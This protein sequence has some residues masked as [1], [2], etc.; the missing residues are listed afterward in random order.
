M[1]VGGAWVG[2]SC[3][4][5]DNERDYRQLNTEGCFQTYRSNWDSLRFKQEEEGSNNRSVMSFRCS[6]LHARYNVRIK[7]ITGPKGILVTLAIPDVV[8]IEDCNHSHE[9]GIPCKCVSTAH[10][11]YVPALCTH[12]PSL[13]PM[14]DSVKLSDPTGKGN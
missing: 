14:D 3:V 6:G 1:A 9:P 8:G 12:R 2:L 11:E 5:S 7:E 4:D 13:L 10:V